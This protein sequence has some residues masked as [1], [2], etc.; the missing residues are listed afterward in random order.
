MK[1]EDVATS[2]ATKRLP[3]GVGSLGKITIRYLPVS[4]L[5]LMALMFLTIFSMELLSQF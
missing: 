4:C 1:S 3:Y 5:L 2:L